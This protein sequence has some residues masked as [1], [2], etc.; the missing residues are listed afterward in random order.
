MATRSARRITYEDYLDFPEGERWEVIDGVAYMCASPNRRHQLILGEIYRQLAN[1]VKSRGGG[2]ALV[3]PFDVVLDPGGDI[4]QPDI[5]FVSDADADVLTAANAWGSPSWV[6]EVLSPS[7]P[8]RDRRL[9]LKRYEHFKVGEY[10]IVDP[11]NDQIEIY[12]LEDGT[13]GEPDIVRPP[14]AP[15]PTALPSFA[16]DLA[17]VFSV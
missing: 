16:L 10:W 11:A 6:V 7:N 13:Y 12:R 3:A 5:V 15:S 17:D 4:V 8:S 9:K 2:V 14:D 1:H